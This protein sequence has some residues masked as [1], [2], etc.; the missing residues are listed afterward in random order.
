M[1][2]SQALAAFA[3]GVILWGLYFAIGFRAFARGFQAGGLGLL[4]TLGLPLLTFVLSRAGWPLM[5]GLLPPGAVARPGSDGTALAW[6]AG[7][8]L[9]ALAALAVARLAQR[10]CVGELRQWYDRHHGAM[11]LE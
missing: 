3:A 7:P 6:L 2:P 1:A 8:A 5:A 9:G 4:L 11:V 10:R